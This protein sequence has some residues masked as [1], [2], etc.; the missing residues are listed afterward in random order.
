MMFKHGWQLQ[1]LVTIE[2]QVVLTYQA[3]LPGLIKKF[4][5]KY[6]FFALLNVIRR[7]GAPQ[8]QCLSAANPQGLGLWERGL[9]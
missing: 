1:L 4:K 3:G 6:T 5:N 8:T 9:S 2:Y 7:L